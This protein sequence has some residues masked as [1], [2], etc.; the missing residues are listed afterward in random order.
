MVEQTYSDQHIRT[1]CDI[2]A[3]KSYTLDMTKTAADCSAGTFTGDWGDPFT[4]SA[5]L[6]RQIT[7][8]TA[9]ETVN[10]LATRVFEAGP[11]KAWVETKYGLIAKMVIGG[12][13]ICACC[14]APVWSPSAA[15][16]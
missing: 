2:K 5:D 15:S 10:G 11:S 4:M 8:S 7:K 9:T 1:Y 13:H 14:T 3:G 12:Q 6:T 16:A